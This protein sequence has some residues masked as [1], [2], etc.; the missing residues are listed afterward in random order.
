M[1]PK[2]LKFINEQISKKK[3]FKILRIS[4]LP[5]LNRS[6]QGKAAF[7]LGESKFFNTILFSPFINEKIDSY[8]EIKNLNHFY[9]PNIAF[10]NNSR[11]IISNLFSIRR[12]ISIIIASVNLIFNKKIYFNDLVHI[13]HIF[14]FVPALILKILG[15]KIIITIHGSDINK[16]QSSILLKTILKLFDSVLCVSQKQY[17]ILS[18]FISKKKLFYIGNGVDNKFF[19]PNRSYSDRK[20]II[21]SVGNLRWQKNYNLLIEAFSIIHENHDDWKLVICGEGPDRK[22]IQELIEVKKLRGNVLLK[23][24]L[25]QKD[26]KKWMQSSRIFVISSK[27]EGFPKALLEAAACGCACVSTNVGDCD[28][29][30]KDIGSI[31]KNNKYDLAKEILKL[32]NSS[33]LSNKN[34]IQAIKKADSFSWKEYID[35]HRNIYNDLL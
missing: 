23:G 20:K 10:P 24:Y 17:K 35:L 2:N 27:V 29:F 31:A 19:K 21:L 34:S 11:K 1:P 32:I 14:Y 9:F 6:G 8:I 26:L 16:I 30:L 33:T 13:H 3:R 18:H 28:Y 12:L 4:N 15:S 25:N 22:K 5:T 7:K